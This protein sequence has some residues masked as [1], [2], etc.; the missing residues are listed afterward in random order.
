MKEILS[1]LSETKNMNFVD[2]K[3][4]YLKYGGEKCKFVCLENNMVNLIKGKIHYGPF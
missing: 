4:V 2:Q 1:A 3:Q